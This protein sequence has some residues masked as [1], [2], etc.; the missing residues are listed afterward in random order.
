M[1][2]YLSVV[3]CTGVRP[4]P[5]TECRH[6]IQ[7]VGLDE[8]PI[9]SLDV[10]EVGP[11]TLETVGALFGVT[12]ER[13]RQIEAS[14]VSKL[15]KALPKALRTSPEELREP[16]PGST[17]ESIEDD[18]G[19]LDIDFKAAVTA[20]YQRIVPGAASKPSWGYV[21]IKKASSTR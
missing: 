4:C 5:Q 2:R 6:H 14:A 10:A 11:Q 19:R 15:K 12:R 17:S 7:P 9:C 1:K 21:P 3:G 8:S 18:A 16:W 20:A 13:I